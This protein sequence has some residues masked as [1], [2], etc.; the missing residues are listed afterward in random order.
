MRLSGEEGE[1]NSGRGMRSQGRAGSDASSRE[2]EECPLA[3]SHIRF[4]HPLPPDVTQQL[5]RPVAGNRDVG[6]A[7]MWWIWAGTGLF[8]CTLL[9]FIFMKS[10][11][12]RTLG[13]WKSKLSVAL[14][15]TPLPG[16]RQGLQLLLGEESQA[17]A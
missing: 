8:S 3:V 15:A 14:G 16:R 2:S 9:P 11:C 10:R 6:T 1:G 4:P 7:Y 5:L 17:A 12:T 13:L